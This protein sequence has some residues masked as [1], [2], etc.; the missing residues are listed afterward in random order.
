MWPRHR[1]KN[2]RPPPARCDG[3]L[4]LGLSDEGAPRESEQDVT[5]HALTEDADEN[6][7]GGGGWKAMD[8]TSCGFIGHR[9]R[10]FRPVIVVVALSLI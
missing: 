8:D 1:C 7:E 10:R 9:I 2:T 3:I 4:L 6:E 5:Y